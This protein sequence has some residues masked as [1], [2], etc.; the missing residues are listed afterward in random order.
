MPFVKA[1]VDM[2]CSGNVTVTNWED[3]GS[4]LFYNLKKF[5]KTE[6]CDLLTGVNFLLLLLL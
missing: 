3:R 1:F 4:T 6:I 5:K 2:G